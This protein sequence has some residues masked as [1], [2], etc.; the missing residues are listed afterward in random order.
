V[1]G[2]SILGKSNRVPLP[3]IYL[4]NK[5]GNDYRI[6]RLSHTYRRNTTD[7]S[8]ASHLLIGIK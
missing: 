4:G 7:E 1:G 6:R 3:F 8:S 2:V 5:F